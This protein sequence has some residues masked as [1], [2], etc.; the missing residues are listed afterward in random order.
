MKAARHIANPRSRKPLKGFRTLQG[1]SA[2]RQA[3]PK[4]QTLEK[5]GGEEILSLENIAF[6]D[7]SVA[8][9]QAMAILEFL[10]DTIYPKPY[11][12]I[13][14]SGGSSKRSLE[15]VNPEK[16]ESM[17]VNDS[18]LYK[19]IP[20]LIDGREAA[21]VTLGHEETGFLQ[22]FRIDG[23]QLGTYNL[24]AGTNPVNLE[25][26]NMSPGIYIY[27]VFVAEELK[28]TDKIVKVR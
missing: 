3:F 19:L 21:V 20:T 5:L 9:F 4:F 7:T 17:P 14:S 12:D 27:R 25:K 26:L 28:N 11:Q 22:L 1:L 6:G 18:R 10:N 13:D 2:C 24:S 15:A 8:A 23:V 16:Q